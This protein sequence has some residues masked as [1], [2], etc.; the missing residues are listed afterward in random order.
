MHVDRKPL[1]LLSQGPTVALVTA[2]LEALAAIG[3][4]VAP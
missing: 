3:A 2:L 4:E 1:L